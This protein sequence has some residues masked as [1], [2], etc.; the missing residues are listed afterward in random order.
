MYFQSLFGF[1]PS[2]AGFAMLL[3]AVPIM[4]MA[5]VGGKLLDRYSAKVP[6]SIGLFL[7]LFAFIWFIFFVSKA[8]ILILLPSLLALGWGYTFVLSPALAVGITAVANT[9]R[10]MA[11]GVLGTLR[12]SGL[13]I[14]IAI[15]GALLLNVQH[16]IFSKDL[17]VNKL[18]SML[19]PNSF[20]GLL[21]KAPKAL[22]AFNKLSSDAQNIVHSSYYNSS[23]FA[24]L[25]SNGFSILIILVAMLWF[26]KRMNT[27]KKH[28]LKT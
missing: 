14:G 3:M 28:K 4:V 6:V 20:D 23:L 9:H 18:T 11:T 15:V 19:D 12:N 27:L 13:T 25:L 7:L 17:R 10:G 21:S 16:H 22:E 26:F 8:S 24:F 1:E 5:P 2:I